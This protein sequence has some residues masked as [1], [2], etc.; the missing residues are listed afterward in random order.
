M[1]AEATITRTL[2]IG[3]I[4]AIRQLV[5]TAKLNVGITTYPTAEE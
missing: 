2:N 3:F 5:T 1:T 4:D